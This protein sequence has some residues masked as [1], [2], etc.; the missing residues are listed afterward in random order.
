MDIARAIANVKE[1]VTGFD[2][3]SFVAD[4]MRRSAVLYQFSIIREA[5]EK[6]TPSLRG[7]YPDVDWRAMIDFRNVVIHGYFGILWER[8]WDTIS[9]DL[10]QLEADLAK[11]LSGELPPANG[12]AGPN[13]ERHSRLFFRHPADGSREAG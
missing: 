6:R 11:V 1:W 7:R 8:V 12:Q 9:I 4:E 3:E 5:A 13:H 2:L 10:T